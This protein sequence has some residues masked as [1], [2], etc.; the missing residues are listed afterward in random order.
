M[1][2]LWVP[3]AASESLKKTSLF[4]FV[5]VLLAPDTWSRHSFSQSN[6][7]PKRAA[8]GRALGPKRCL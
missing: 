2:A 1:V 6:S 5:S 3:N 7:A 8:H 4:L